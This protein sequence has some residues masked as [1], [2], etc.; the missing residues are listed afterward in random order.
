VNLLDPRQIEPALKAGYARE[1]RG[2]E[3]REFL[4]L[5]FKLATPAIAAKHRASLMQ[6]ELSL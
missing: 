4:G 3:D 6:F 1:D 2:R 5:A